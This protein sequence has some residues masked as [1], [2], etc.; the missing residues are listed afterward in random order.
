LVEDR[1]CD[2]KRPRRW[3]T[4]GIAHHRR[5]AH[6]RPSQT[7]AVAVTVLAETATLADYHAK[8]LS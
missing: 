3:R 2:L 7:D 1:R 8:S 5:R 6:R 4:D